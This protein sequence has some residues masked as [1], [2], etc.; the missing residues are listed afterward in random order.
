MLKDINEFKKSYQPRACAI[1]KDDDTIAAD[2]TS[3]L[4]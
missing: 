1:K 4:S 2:P 3:I